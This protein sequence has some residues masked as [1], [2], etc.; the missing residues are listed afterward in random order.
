MQIE[1]SSKQN[2]FIDK[3]IKKSAKDIWEEK[4][5]NL[6][7]IVL[8]GEEDNQQIEDKINEWILVDIK[9]AE[10]N[11][12][13]YKCVCG[14]TLRYQYVIKH[15]ILDITYNLGCECVKKYTGIDSKL[16]NRVL[17][18]KDELNSMVDEITRKLN[19]SE[20]DRQ[21]Y[22]LDYDEIPNMI[23]QQ[24]LIGLPLTDKQLEKVFKVIGKDNNKKNYHKKVHN[25]MQEL[26]K[27]QL[28][29]LNELDY[30]DKQPLIIS[31]MDGKKIYSMDELKGVELSNIA[32][33]KV[34]L[35]LPFTDK[36]VR[37]IKKG[38]KTEDI[39]YIEIASKK[40]NKSQ[41]EF[42]CSRMSLNQRKETAK[43][44]V[45]GTNICDKRLVRGKSLDKNIRR[46]I[47]LGI[48]LTE[49][50]MK[51]LDT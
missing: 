42:W 51:S 36:E 28:E 18:K 11:T 12:R 13:P 32:L 43:Y 45:E 1:L 48:P 31:L 19:E 16:V 40:L 27:E 20:I 50:Q 6:K 44:I 9:V 34:E 23:R 25:V 14:R 15:K 47:E 26:T 29:F 37:D 21:L 10:E 39:K 24:L 17:L 38:K 2:E 3:Y 33:R 7:G 46:Q 22:L 35:N 5:I 49:K 4:L 8:N 30:E 41:Y